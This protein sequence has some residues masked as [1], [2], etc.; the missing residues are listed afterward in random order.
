MSD[1][2]KDPYSGIN[3]EKREAKIVGMD[4][5]VKFQ[6]TVEFPDFFNDNSVAIVSSKY[7]CNSSKKKETSLKE[8]ID[9]VSDTISNFGNKDNYFNTSDSYE[10]FK[11]KLKY[12][13]V[14]QYF[15]FNSPVYFNVGLKD[16][17]QT[18][19]CIILNM[20]DNMDSIFET[21]K[22]ESRI[23]KQGSGVGYNLSRLRSNKEKVSAGGLAS[24]PVSFLKISDVSAGVIRSGGTLRRSAKMACLNIDHPD[25][26]EF[27]SCKKDEEK[28]LQLLRNNGIQARNGQELSDEVFFQN[29][30]IS[31]RL[32][33]EF[34]NAVENDGDFF[35][36]FI[37]TGTPC[38]KYKAKELLMQ[39]AQNA[40][41]CADPGILYHDNTNDY[42]TCKNSGI[43][44]SSNPCGEFV[45]LNNSAC[46]LAS[47]NLIKFF[48]DSGKTFNFELFKD[49]IETVI[50]AQDILIHNSYYPHDQIKQ[51][52]ID[53]RPI[54]I[55]YTNLGSLL[56][57]MGL[58]YDSDEGRNVASAIT[59]LLTGVAYNQSNILSELK[60]RFNKFD[61]NKQCMYDVL[62]KH[63]DS[64]N[65]FQNKTGYLYDCV[66]N[67][68]NKIS[69]LIQNDKTFRNS[70]VSLLAPCG[71]I[72]YLMGSTTTGIE[73][74][75]SHIKYKNL[76]GTDGGSIKLINDL[77]P[78]TLKNLG[79]TDREIELLKTE[80]LSVGHFE[81]SEILKPE[82]LAIFDTSVAPFGGKRSIHYNG[83]INMMAAIQP[84]VSGAISKT[85]NAP[86]DISVED[87]YN[88]YLDSWKKGLKG[89][90]I[91][92]DGSKTFQAISTKEDNKQS[93][94]QDV[95]DY[96]GPDE[97]EELKNQLEII[98][99]RVLAR[100]T[101]RRRLPNERS[102]VNH[103][104]NIGQTK[105]YIN[106]GLYDDNSVGEV[107][108]KVAK[109]G[110]TLSG[111]LDA[112]ATI[113][114]ISLQH[115]VPLKVLVRKLMF[116]RFEPSGFTSNEN[117]RMATSIVDYVFRYLGIKFLNE[118]DKHDLGLTIKKKEIVT[119]DE[120]NQ[121]KLVTDELISRIFDDD[122]IDLPKV[123]EPCDDDVDV[124]DEIGND[125]SSSCPECGS[126]LV[127]KGS[128][129]FCINCAYNDG[130][131][132]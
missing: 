76:S 114:S 93:D 80:L 110:S 97:V 67:V 45:F 132:G 21:I 68:W 54:G 23:F 112:L 2:D 109:Q 6:Q 41:E 57:I 88:I 94:K 120:T 40:W 34:M 65:V 116:Q 83:H 107:F 37:T 60:S 42:N 124:D 78:Q 73:P 99:N 128:C 43:I 13:Q 51:N 129:Y 3:W 31:V 121:I 75:F 98:K 38:K 33:N 24:G 84:F 20:D 49:V 26:E 29:T 96:F 95:D 62:K 44:E 61:E 74:E 105:G 10:L 79:Y 14:H 113:T 70:Q 82:H 50:T 125:S 89:I 71:T 103:K 104:F 11:F 72:S 115:G 106:C 108:I 86:N 8:L 101:I 77:I 12:Y 28:K 47:I 52:S 35:T 66:K 4:G 53:F 87:V 122:T 36:K 18:S 69:E 7:L 9:R 111:L 19:A 55:G 5:T 131:C 58:P 56:M 118:K 102:A 48:D 39:I 22:L 127:R 85:I 17:C 15:A 126:I 1:F 59:A 16:D 25:I 32:T 92:R 46:N 130:S 63:I 30:N 117:I 81:N 90:T 91:Y 123:S 100:K 27:I 64:I 119:D